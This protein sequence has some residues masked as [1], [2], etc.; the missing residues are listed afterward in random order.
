MRGL[1][2]APSVRQLA[3]AYSDLQFAK[4]ALANKKLALYSQ[5]ARLD[6]RLGEILVEY[7]ARFWRRHDPADLNSRLRLQAWPAAFGA[8]LEHTPFFWAQKERR[9]RRGEAEKSRLAPARRRRAALFQKW[10]ESVMDSIPPARGEL[11]FFGAYGM[12]SKLQ[13]KEAS[14]ATK[15]YRKWGYF[16]KDLLVNKAEPPQKTL[17]PL[18]RRRLLLDQLLKRKKRLKL[19][20]YLAEL[21]FQIHRRQAQRDLK[22][23][24][25]LESRGRAKNRVYIQKP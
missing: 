22:S 24:P 17:I 12:G 6:S 11:F 14:H 4:K 9:E 1:K 10:S 18:P 13:R 2:E 23:H 19:E 3:A 16:G 20:D 21:S 15:L 25:R 8:L 7:I 5:W